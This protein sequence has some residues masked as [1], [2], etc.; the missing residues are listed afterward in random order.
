MKLITPLLLFILIFSIVSCKTA[1]VQK[2]PDVFSYNSGLSGTEIRVEFTKGA[3]FN[4][5][6]YA[7]WVE[8]EMG[9]FVQTLYVSESIGKGNFD[10]GDAST[11]KWLPGEIMRPAALPYWSHR[12]GIMN[13]EGLYLPDA[14]N[15]IADAYTGPTPIGNFIMN[16]RI[17]NPELRKFSVYMEINQTWDWN[18]FWTNAKYPDDL[19]YK[20]SCQP[21]LVYMADINLDS[22]IKNYTMKVIGHSHYSGLTGELFSDLSTI[23]TAL[24]IAKEVKIQVK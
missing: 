15:P 9:K 14:K 3:S 7:I 1:E 13:S 12:R 23:T 18:E 22:E 5:P 2:P 4:Y 16:T 21:A 11:G 17:E 19:E 10:H 24:N 8:D 6:L 20:T